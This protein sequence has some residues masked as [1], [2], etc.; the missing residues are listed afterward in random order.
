MREEKVPEATVT[1]RDIDATLKWS[2]EICRD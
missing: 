2:K 1:D